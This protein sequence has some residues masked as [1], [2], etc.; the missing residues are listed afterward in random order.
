MDAVL[1]L[2]GHHALFARDG[3]EALEMFDRAQSPF[4]LIITDHAMVRVSGLDLVRNLREKGFAGEIVVLT[5][6]TGRM[7]QQQ[8][9]QFEV[10]GIMGKPFD[11]AELR[12]WIDCIHGCRNRAF[13]REYPPGRLRAVDFCWV[14]HN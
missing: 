7:E 12:H 8:Y 13:P 10:A 9:S 1:R 6:Y 2:A 14:N 11:I 4:D 5:A 3:D